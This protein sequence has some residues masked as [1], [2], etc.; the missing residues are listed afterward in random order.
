MPAREGASKVQTDN[1]GKPI[2]SRCCCFPLIVPP[3]PQALCHLYLQMS[4]YVTHVYRSVWSQKQWR[5]ADSFVI[6]N[7]GCP[8]F[9]REVDLSIRESLG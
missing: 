1:Q 7:L 8:Q 9:D 3:Q 4:P 5:E 2:T 6:H